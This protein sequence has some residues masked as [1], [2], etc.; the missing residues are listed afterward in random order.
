M[1]ICAW[2]S[3]HEV[4]RE[5]FHIS[6]QRED[7]V[8]SIPLHGHKDLCEWVCVLS[9]EML[10]EVNGEAGRLET[11][12]SI[13]LIRPSDRHKLSGRA[14]SIVNVA[15]PLLW[16]KSFDA[17]WGTPGLCESLLDG[18]PPPFTKVS[19]P[20]FSTL[21]ALLAKTISFGRGAFAR[22][23]LT[24]FFSMMFA[25]YFNMYLKS[26]AEKLEGAPE[27]FAETIDWLERNADRNI[28]LRQLREK[29]CKCPE[30]ISREF[31]KRFGFGPAEWLLRQKM[32]KAANMLESSNYPISEIASMS[33]FA[34]LSHFSRKFRERYGET[35]SCYRK[36]LGGLRLSAF[37]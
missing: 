4:S 12:G 23:H 3:H 17:L 18:S 13:T 19:E 21:E 22:Q 30:H 37:R 8:N 31:I 27:W 1:H 16:F 34:N 14:F 33:G 28:T 2:S 25:S 29:A 20:E 7:F 32:A 35:P 11:R 15:F 36:E 5:N 24:V 26:H 6:L 9:G 10:H